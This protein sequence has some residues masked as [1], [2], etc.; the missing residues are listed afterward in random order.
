MIKPF[1]NSRRFLFLRGSRRRVQLGVPPS[2]TERAEIQGR[3]AAGANRARPLKTKSGGYIA[4]MSAL[5]ISIIISIVLVSLGQSAFF[6]RINISDAHL[7]GKS[8]SLAEACVDTALLKL[9]SSSS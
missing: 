3:F 4:I 7:K 2:G 8:R 9:V 1:L 5:I 6:N